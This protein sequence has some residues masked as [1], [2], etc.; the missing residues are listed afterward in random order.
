MTTGYRHPLYAASLAEHGTPR[1][2]PASDGWI[3]ERDIPG[4]TGR[5]AMGCYPLFCCG[6]WDR[7]ADDLRE[8]GDGLVSLTL[9]TD[10]FGWRRRLQGTSRCRS[11]RRPRAR[12]L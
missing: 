5:D 1:R 10:P 11:E 3:L 12:C 6:R 9:V 7:L 8:L 2:L 4:F